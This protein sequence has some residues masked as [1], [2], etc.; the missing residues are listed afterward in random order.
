MKLLQEIR[1]TIGS[2]PPEA[3]VA[4]ISGMIADGIDD[5]KELAEAYFMRGKLMWRMGRRADATSDYAK[6]AGLDPD[7]KA[8]KALEHARDV[9][10]F[11]NP[12]LYNP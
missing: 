2:I 8:V 5:S 11:F 6:A 3:A 12:D 4:A 7:S 9:E 10:A 1:E